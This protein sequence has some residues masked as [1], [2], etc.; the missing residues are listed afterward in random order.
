MFNY[1]RKRRAYLMPILKM[2]RKAFNTFKKY[3]Y[4]NYKLS[5]TVY[6]MYKDEQIKNCYEH[7][8]KY[9]KTAVLLL[10]LIHI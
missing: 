10:S 9:F 2:L 8:K 4:P 6:D 5:P 7:F 3:A 1:K